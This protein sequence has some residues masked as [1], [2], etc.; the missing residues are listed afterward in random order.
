MGKIAAAALALLMLIA[1]LASA[2]AGGLLSAFGSNGTEP[3][4]AALADIPSGYLALYVDA[5]TTCPG[6]DWSVLAA[7]GKAESDHGRSTLPGVTDG[8]NYAG[9]RG[10]MQ[11]LP[12]T[13]Q[14]VVA[15]H[16]PP[17]GGATPP[18]HT[19]PTTPSTPPPHT[20]ATPAPATATASPTP[21]TRT[22]TP[23]GTS[24]KSS[25]RPRHTPAAQASVRTPPPLPLLCKRSTT[26]KASSDSPMSGAETDP[27]PATPDSTAPA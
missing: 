25:L 11:F 27:A 8:A 18:R 19:T 13:F 16:P 12:P 14:S 22:T 2:G 26:P 3:S 1:V 5:A 4:R 24:R 15:K 9:A 20:C 23:T 10:P 17:K 6:L 21:S 7:V